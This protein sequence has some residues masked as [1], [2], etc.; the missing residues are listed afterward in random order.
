MRSDRWLIPIAFLGFVSLGLPDGVLGVAWP[1]LRRTFERPIDHLGFILLASMT[2]YLTAS[3]AGGALVSWLKVGRLLTGSGLL[4][5]AGA[6]IWGLTP[7]WTPILV[8]ALALGL[9]ATRGLG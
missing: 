5:A 7:A 9:G 6:T 2:G 1:S 8:G 4:V 3:L